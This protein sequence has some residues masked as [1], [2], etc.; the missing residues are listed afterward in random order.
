MRKT[1]DRYFEEVAE[2]IDCRMRV[3]LPTKSEESIIVL[4]CCIPRPPAELLEPFFSEFAASFREGILKLG[5]EGNLDNYS[6]VERHAL[7]GEERLGLIL[8]ADHPDMPHRW[9]PI[10]RDLLEELI[11]E[12][13]DVPQ[14]LEEIV[15][16]PEPCGSL[17]DLTWE[18]E[19]VLT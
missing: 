14:G 15:R 16:I 8:F 4:L 2:G 17:Q 13:L 18:R 19:R 12:S 9:Q 3:F 6:L 10:D 1:L 11:G 5:E 7:P